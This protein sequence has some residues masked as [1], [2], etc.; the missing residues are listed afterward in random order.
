VNQTVDVTTIY[1]LLYIFRQKYNCNFKSK[2]RWNYI[3]S[4]N[5]IRHD[6]TAILL[7]VALNT[8]NPNPRNI[9][10]E[11]TKVDILLSNG[12]SGSTRTFDRTIRPHLNR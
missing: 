6:I 10:N 1:L 9:K 7:K 4:K 5:I 11:F 2:G 8:I 3:L 12:F